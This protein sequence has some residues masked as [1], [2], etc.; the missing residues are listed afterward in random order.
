MSQGAIQ[1]TP[2]P[3]T[4]TATAT[5]PLAAR[6]FLMVTG[7]FVATGGMDR[8]NLALWAVYFAACAGFGLWYSFAAAH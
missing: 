5:A 4:A 3:M 7:D 6:P 8:A 2:E 1:T